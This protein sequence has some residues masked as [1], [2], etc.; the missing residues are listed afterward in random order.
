MRNSFDSKATTIAETSIINVG[1]MRVHENEK[2]I[3]KGNNVQKMKVSLLFLYQIQFTAT[4]EA[5]CHY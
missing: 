3:H 1:K 5:A 2:R 4:S